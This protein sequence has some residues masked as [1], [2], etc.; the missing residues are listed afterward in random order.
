MSI[1]P[2]VNEP[3]K[4]YAPG[5]PERAEIRA[6]I[7][8]L[9]AAAPELGPVI[10]GRDVTTGV[11]RE[12][13]EPHAHRRVLARW[14]SAG[15][16][17]TRQAI[18]AARAA[19]AEWSSWTLEQ[20]AAVFLRAAE[21]L[22]GPWRAR[23]ERGHHAR[24]VEDGPAGGD[25]LR[26]RGDRLLPLQPDVREPARGAAADLEPGGLEPARAAA[27]RRLRLRRQPVQL[28]GHRR[29]PAH[30]SGAHGQHRGL[31]AREHRG[32]LGAPDDAA[33]AG[34]RPA[35]RRDQPRA[36][37]CSGRLGSVPRAP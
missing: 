30:R 18:D 9:R 27:A 31:E 5:T 36:G 13:R 4:S 25:R 23:P 26:L 15:A 8:S 28:H 20:R 34:G 29:E 6:A 37:R 35:R 1:P 16:D 12:V 17:E 32:G 19:R 22:A 24:P 3:V 11:L 21:L 2:P 33:A 7:A 10:G 14:H